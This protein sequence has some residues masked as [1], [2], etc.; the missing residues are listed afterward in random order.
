MLNVLKIQWGN[1]SDRE[2]EET[3][4]TTST[5][6]SPKNCEHVAETAVCPWNLFILLRQQILDYSQRVAS[7]KE[8]LSLQPPE[9]RGAATWLNPGQ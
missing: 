5:A 4:E 3:T 6:N 7:W 9:Q 2:T 8:A 1:Y